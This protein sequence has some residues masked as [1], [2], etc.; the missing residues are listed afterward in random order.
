MTLVNAETGEIVADISADEAREITDRIKVGVEAVWHLIVEAYNRGAHRALGY[1]S[2]DD[3]CTR[4]FGTARL[5][6]PR[7]ER[8][9]VV[10]SLRDSGLSIRAI[11][12]ATGISR[13]TVQGD[14]KQV[15]QSSP[16]AS[17]TQEAYDRMREAL[18]A[19]SKPAEVTGTDGK[20]YTVKDRIEA[21]KAKHPT[22][23]A[24]GRSRAEIEAKVAKAKQMAAEGYTS[25]QIAAAIGVTEGSMA[26]FRRRHGVEVPADAIVGKRRKIDANRVA[27][28]AAIAL[29][30]IVLSLDLVGENELA[31]LDPARAEQWAASFTNSLRSL[32][33]FHK[34]LKETAHVEQ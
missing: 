17:D 7:E 25:K 24:S 6:L 3:Y 12:A 28:E 29:E 15:A 13:R 5:K 2:W 34:H 8:Q 31:E 30:G 21:A 14:L 22:P 27:E 4:E 11:T 23:T 18:V 32:N 20:T 19:K 9:E 1:S 10:A 16:P 26:D 33:R